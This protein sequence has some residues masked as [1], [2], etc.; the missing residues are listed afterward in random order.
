MLSNSLPVRDAVLF[1]SPG[2]KIFLNRGVAGIDG[3]LSTALGTAVSS[4]SPTCCMIGDLAF[5]H[6]SNA[7]LSIRNINT[8]FVIVVINNNGGNIFRMLPIH[9]QNDVYTDYFETPQEADIEHLALA[10][11][12]DFK[13][14]KTLDELEKLTFTRSEPYSKPIVI[15]CRTNPEESM[16][17]RRKLWGM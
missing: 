15:E 12:L 4:G 11:S 10:H 6:D 16:K 2:G 17:L 5:L 1:G 13:R 9:E 8:P 14:I 3:I 7:L